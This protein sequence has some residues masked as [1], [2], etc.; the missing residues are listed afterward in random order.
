LSNLIGEPKIK[1]FIKRS[2]AIASLEEFSVEVALIE[3][4]KANYSSTW[5]KCN[6]HRSVG[7]RAP[8]ASKGNEYSARSQ[9]LVEDLNKNLVKPVEV[10]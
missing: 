6:Y 3:E 8:K 5:F 1:V 7:P 10:Y 4:E 9:V 2:R